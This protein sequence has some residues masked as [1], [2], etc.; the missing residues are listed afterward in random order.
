MHDHQKTKKLIERILRTLI[1]YPEDAVVTFENV[2]GLTQWYLKVRGEDQGKARGREAA[3]IIAVQYIVGE[4]GAAHQEKQRVT[5]LES[6]RRVTGHR[7]PLT[8]AQTY[9]PGDA[10]ELLHDIL[11]TIL[12][13]PFRIDV[14]T[15]QDTPPL[16]YDFHITTQSEDDQA[17]LLEPY[18]D[19]PSRN[20]LIASLGTLWRAYA[21][22][23]GVGF[24]ISTKSR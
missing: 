6:D 9:H 2:P 16:A 14:R 4:I 15:I 22:R 18:D 19:D 17:A 8:Q 1:E 23:E 12:T 5:L 10:H 3:H 20:T 24:T 11:S 7:S 13:S 21:N